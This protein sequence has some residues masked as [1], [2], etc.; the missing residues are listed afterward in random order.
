MA[1]AVQ[2]RNMIAGGAVQKK[3]AISGGL[4]RDGSPA[5]GSMQRPRDGI[6]PT[7]DVDDIEGGHRVTITSA[8]GTVSFDVMNGQRG[9]QGDKGDPGE[10]VPEGGADGQTIVMDGDAAAWK[11]PVIEL[12]AGS[13]ADLAV[14]DEAVTDEP[15]YT[16][17]GIVELQPGTTPAELDYS[18][19]SAACRLIINGVKP[20]TVPTGA[21]FHGTDVKF[22]HGF[23]EE[24]T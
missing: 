23:E 20:I 13:T 14:T 3:A 2:H 8:D 10:G 18:Y 6:S 19:D 7:I 24:E 9:L 12:D 22:R 4:T 1:G 5:G 11:T 17:D 21:T 15:T 16:P